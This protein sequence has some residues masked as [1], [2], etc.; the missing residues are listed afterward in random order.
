MPKQNVK[1]ECWFPLCTQDMI[2]DMA[3]DRYEKGW[4]YERLGEKYGFH[5]QTVARYLRAYE[6]YGKSVFAADV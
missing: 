1:S 3:K 2:V 5:H 4:T 6:K